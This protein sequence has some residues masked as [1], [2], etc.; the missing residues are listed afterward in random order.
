MAFGHICPP[1]VPDETGACLIYWFDVLCVIYN[2]L[3]SGN[4]SVGFPQQE[5]WQFGVALTEST[6]LMS[7]SGSCL[8]PALSRQD[9]KSSRSDCCNGSNLLHV[10][11]SMGGKAA[12][13]PFVDDKRAQP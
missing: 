3:G 8:E 13:L 2:T 11:L 4:Q 5:V 7:F 9:G 6:R 12:D 10:R 1:V